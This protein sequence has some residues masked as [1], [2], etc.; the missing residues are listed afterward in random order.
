MN[1]QTAKQIF[2]DLIKQIKLTEEERNL[3]YSALNF[4]LALDEKTEEVK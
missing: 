1:K 4:L 3:C 2:T